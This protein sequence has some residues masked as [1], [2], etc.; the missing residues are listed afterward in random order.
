MNDGAC[1]LDLGPTSVRYQAERWTRI[2]L[3]FEFESI[4]SYGVLDGAFKQFAEHA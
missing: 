1:I 2:F 3:G 4:C